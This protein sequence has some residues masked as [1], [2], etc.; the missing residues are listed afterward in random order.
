MPRGTVSLPKLRKI[1]GWNN[2]FAFD[3]SQDADCPDCESGSCETKDLI[4][5]AQDPIVITEPPF[6]IAHTLPLAKA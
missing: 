3:L 2:L 5:P 6:E 4:I 1:K